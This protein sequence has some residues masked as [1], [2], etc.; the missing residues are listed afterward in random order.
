M[1][2]YKRS[3]FI[4][5]FLWL[6]I[7]L[8]FG[9]AV[10][11]FLAYARSEAALFEQIQTNAK[12]IARCAAMN[13]SGDVLQGILAGEEESETYARI[14]DELTL[15][16]DNAD[17]EYIYT[18]R[19][20]GEETYEFIVDADPE[21]P[22]AIG[23]ECE[24]TEAL[25]IAF[26]QQITTA[27]DEPFSDEWGSH[28]SAYSPVIYQGQTVGVV[29]V[30]ISANWIEDQT[31]ALRNL[32]IFTC[33]I[34]YIVSLLVL[35]LLMSKF[36]KGIK[37]L[38]EKVK[39]LASGSGDLTKEIDIYT[40]N[41]LGEIAE[42]MNVFIRQ[43]RVLVKEVAL[44]T[45]GILSTGEELSRTVKE[46]TQIMSH[47]NAEI[48][49]INI[50]MERSV[51]S[52]RLM[53][54]SLAES[55]ERVTIFADN[56]EAI[57]KTVRQANENAQLTSNVARQ[58]RQ[59][60]MDSIRELQARMQKTNQDTQQIM[61]VK[62][63]AEEIGTIANQTRMLSLNAQIEAARAGTMG[64][65]FAVVA[66]E[67]GKLSDE[68]DSAVTEINSINSQVQS[69]VE[70]LSDVFAEM[71]RFV[72]EDVA[73]DYDSFAALGE[74]YGNSTG[75]ILGQMNE[76]G[77][78]SGEIADTIKN[79]NRDVYDITQMVSSIAGNAN[80]LAKSNQRIAD[81]F[82]KLNEAS[83]KNTEHSEKL[84]TQVNKYTF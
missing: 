5:L 38:N 3:I 77:N 67:V 48:E 22:A 65:G 52:S 56:V 42:H 33:I 58:N 57:C 54:E 74:E 15:F 16:R 32:V 61:R 2:G 63:I 80:D 26:A 84:S 82:N 18:L 72:S 71:I 8:L 10:L 68:I 45:E 21:E 24:A 76:I 4:Q 9:N 35:W 30:D 62:Q 17:I 20:V 6:A 73:R 51:S 29:G 78:Q 19:Q 79:V 47:M 7:L 28:V 39:D 50:N 31:T 23:D 25:N 40:G 83:D 37:K 11:G 34:T 64:A 1:K 12:N 69:A 27:D 49:D 75:V 70:A 14:V 53:S 55:A 81:S 13:V 59:K 41:E 46:N 44:S 43:I 60:A 66:T 36:V